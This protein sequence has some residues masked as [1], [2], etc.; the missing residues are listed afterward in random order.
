MFF[1]CDHR[2]AWRQ[3]REPAAL[4]AEQQEDPDNR[5]A[6]LGLVALVAVMVGLSFAAVPLYRMF[7]RATGYGGR[8]DALP[9]CRRPCSINMVMSAS[10]PMSIRACLGA[11][12]PVE[13]KVT[14]QASARRSSRISGATN[15]SKETEAAAV[16]NVAPEVIGRYFT[17]IECFCFKQQTLASRAS[18]EMPVTFFVDPKIVDDED[19]KNVSEITL[20]YT[21]YPKCGGRGAARRSSRTNSR[22]C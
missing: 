14:L 8:P 20:S 9:A 21:F 10:M 5:R 6:A 22:S 17:K 16:F 1:H 4:K 13:P 11:S 18:V 3:C 12:S 2:Q 19:T 15:N 7:C